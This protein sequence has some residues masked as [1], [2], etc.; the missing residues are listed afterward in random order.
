[1][2]SVNIPNCE[3]PI[4]LINRAAINLIKQGGTLLID[5][6]PIYN[7]NST[8]ILDIPYSKLYKLLNSHDDREIERFIV[9]HPNTSDYLFMLAPCNK[10]ILCK[11][12]KQ[13]DLIFRAS[14]ECASYDTPAYFF[15]LTYK[16]SELPPHGELCYKDIQNFFK[17]LRK[18]WDKRNIKHNIRYLV[19]GEYGKKTGRCHWH[20][21]LFN[22]P[23]GASETNPRLH[24][25]LYKDIFN[26]W[27]KCERQAFDFGMCR[28]GAASYATKYAAKLHPEMHGHYTK[29][30][31]HCSTGKGGLGSPTID[32]YIEYLHNNPQCRSIEFRDFNGKWQSIQFSTYIMSRV[33]PSPT[34]CVPVQVKQAYKEFSDICANLLR[35]NLLNYDVAFDWIERARPYKNAL[36][37]RLSSKDF[38]DKR[39]CCPTFATFL[40]LR[41]KKVLLDLFKYLK[42]NDGVVN[43]D[44]LN[45]YYNFKNIAPNQIKTNNAWR[46]QRLR[47]KQVISELKETL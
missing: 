38:K 12:R 35:Y 24:K 1:M 8:N 28:G 2:N 34:R 39:Y 20:V 32:K 37:H 27:G 5:G 4:V 40:Y 45:I 19:S 33:Y 42:R 36:V 26:S 11:S 3:N 23:Y 43:P 21:I 44:Y 41:S 18:S 25:Q 9:H 15:T 46:V 30:M 47:E 31:I 16:D 13:N 14:L 17:R 22:N 29:P 10:C 7:I 6:E